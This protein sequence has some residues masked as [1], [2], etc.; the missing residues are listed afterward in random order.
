MKYTE[1]IQVKSKVYNEGPCL[2]KGKVKQNVLN[3][4]VVI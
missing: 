3:T 2:D 1:K 4:S